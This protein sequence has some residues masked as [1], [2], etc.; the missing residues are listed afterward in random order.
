[1]LIPSTTHA[2]V[3][4]SA[5]VLFGLV[6]VVGTTDWRPPGTHTGYAPTQP[7]QYSHRLH[8]G[9][10]GMDC[11]FCHFGARTSRHA[12][13]P[14]TSVCMNC[15]ESVSTGFDEVL[16]ERELAEVEG[17][18]PRRLVSPEIQKIYDAM[19]LD[20]NLEPNGLG[21]Q[22]IP[23]V[24]VHNLP[25]FVAFDHSVHVSRGLACQVCHGPVQSME[26]VRQESDLSMGWCVNCHRENGVDPAM[27]TSMGGGAADHFRLD[28]IQH[29]STDC[30][31]CHY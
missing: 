19:G 5:A 25:D 27:G 7:I 26:R 23:W 1:M 3:F 28:D 11:M 12:G 31:V 10:L 8:A 14:P 13:I 16:Q 29:V 22:T 4:L 18:D 9:E 30:S 15:H 21:P 6:A 20:E 24:R 2:R 17:R